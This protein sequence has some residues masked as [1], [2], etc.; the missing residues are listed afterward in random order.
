[1]V[2]K[3]DFYTD[4]RLNLRY[5]LT[6]N[7]ERDADLTLESVPGSGP[8]SRSFVP[9]TVSSR[10]PLPLPSRF[11][12]NPPRRPPPGHSVANVRRPP[13]S[14]PG[15]RGFKR[16]APRVERPGPAAR[17]VEPSA[18]ERAEIGPTHLQMSFGS[19]IPSVFLRLIK[20]Y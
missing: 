10:P 19:R 16:D 5:T 8:F 14:V 6:L 7:T 20:Y 4:E 2:K 3:K 9:K 11:C 17:D 1:M 18:E 12:P 15:Q 13:I